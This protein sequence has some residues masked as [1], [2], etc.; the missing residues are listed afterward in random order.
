M[1]WCVSTILY[2]VHFSRAARGTRACRWLSFHGGSDFVLYISGTGGWGFG[3]GMFK[4][5]YTMYNSPALRGGHAL[6][7]GSL[8]TVAVILFCI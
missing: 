1:F 4:Q 8:F 5:F 6:A 7:G 2:H 3:F